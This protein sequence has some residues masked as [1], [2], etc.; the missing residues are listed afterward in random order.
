[1]QQTR[2]QADSGTRIRAVALALFASVA[3]FATL[4]G[5]AKK[6]TTVAPPSGHFTVDF[7]NAGTQDLDPVDYSV[8]P[9]V[10]SAGLAEFAV[11]QLLAG[12][13]TARDT[14]ILFPEGT[15]LDVTVHGD[16]AV[17]NI[18]GPLAK[19]YSGGAGDETAMFKSL[20]YTL[21]NIPG[22]TQVEVLVAGKKRAALSGGHLEL[23][24]PL[25][26]DT[27]AQ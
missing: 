3:V 27:F 16:T 18:N 22:V 7:V 1:M 19:S 6:T 23:D 12:P 17:V 15:L 10:N 11:T 25:T 9:N 26:R 2:A 13:A 4:A 21:T 24:A 20:T 8:D 5:C 14:V